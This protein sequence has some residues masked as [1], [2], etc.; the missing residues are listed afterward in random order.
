MPWRKV[1]LV[2]GASI[3]SRDFS[4]RLAPGKAKRSGRH[5]TFF[6]NRRQQQGK[7]ALPGGLDNA[8]VWIDSHQQEDCAPAYGNLLRDCGELAAGKKI[9]EHV[10][11]NGYY[12][13]VY[14]GNHLVQMYSKCGSLEDAK[15]VFDGM[16]RRDSISWSKMIAGYVRHGL[17]REAIKLYKAMAIDPDG[18]TFSAVLNA[19]SSLGPRAL[20]VGKEIHAHMKRIWLKP[21]VFVDSAL[22]TMFAK[23][24]S[25]KESREVF[26][27][28]RWKDVLFWNSMIVAYSQSGHPREAIELFKSM[29][30]SSP[31][32][33]P[34]AITYTTVLAACSAVEAL[35]QGKEVHRQM[36]DAGF[37]FDAA[38][39]NSLVNMYAKCGSI[40]E[41]RE[42]F[43]G[44]KQ[45]T[46]VSWTGIISAYVRKGHPREALDLYRKMGSEGVEP[47]G[48]TFASVLSACSSLGALE[49]GKAVHAQMKA[50]GYKPDLAVANALVSLYGKCGSVDSARKVFDRMKIRNVVSWT[51]MISSY[52]HHR[53]SEEAIQL[54]K[55]MDVAPNAVTLASVL[56]ACAS[57]GNAEEGRAVHEKLAS[58]TTGLATDEVLQNALLNMYAKCGD[59]DA[60]R[61]IFDAMAVKD[62]VSW[63]AMISAYVQQ[64]VTDLSLAKSLHSQ[65][66]SA[67]FHTDS[68]VQTSLVNLYARCGSLG[69]ARS[70]FAEME[71][72]DTMSWSTL[73]A[74]YTQH[75]RGGEAVEMCRSMELEGVQASSFIYGTVL[76]AC[77]QA[78]LLESAR[79]YFGCL[80]RDCG[81]PAKLEDYV[82]MATV[83]GRAGRLAEAEELLAV[84]PFEAEF[85]AWMGLLAACK[86]HNDVERGARVAEV[87]F[88]LE[89]LNEAPYVLLSNIYV[90]AGRQE[91]AARVRRK[92]GDVIAAAGSGESIIVS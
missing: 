72:R 70:V 12:E 80:T 2:R 32:V 52:A 6:D 78:G 3:V 67:G 50:A 21:D 68:V 47:N 53:H 49:E 79:H 17:A 25:L 36:V 55:A 66:T 46:V 87:L 64:G 9:H 61:K 59:G 84:M 18:F 14:V 4:T 62:A 5:S 83:L 91:E 69:D 88:R 51:A 85:V 65:V 24:G 29:G 57:L 42:V 23:C 73:I 19:C 54:Y 44:M 39:E 7:S 27:D 71:V 1:V 76:T 40:T 45:R 43:D 60:A 22:V 31:P 33:E 48:I 77:S 90:A 86:A 63:S 82:C 92:M 37:Q 20:E 11:K 38:A 16:R 81:A 34:N 30:S 58:T 13:N 89:P 8:L 41:A 10:V 26:D 28:C 75:G 15:K 56:S 74:A 35:E